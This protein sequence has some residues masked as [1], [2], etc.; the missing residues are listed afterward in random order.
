[1]SPG[2]RSL[3]LP[4]AGRQPAG[5]SPATPGPFAWLVEDLL[6]E[7]RDL[8]AVE[9]F[10]S[11]HDQGKVPSQSRYYQDLIPLSKP[12]AGQQY[13]FEVDLDSCTG[14]K[15]CVTACHSLNGLDDRETWRDVGLLVGGTMEQPVVQHV[16]TACHHCLEPECL[17]GCPVKAYEKDP[18][19]GIVKHLDDQCIGCQY[20]VFK[21]P[22]D[23]PK[24]NKRLGIVRK[25]DMCHGRLASGEAPACVQ[26]C[27]N[28]A[29]KIRV[30]DKR[31]VVEDC[32]SNRFVAGAPEPQF[33]LPSTNYVGK[34][35]LPRNLLPADFYQ[36]KPQPAHA[37]LAV[38][39][40]LTQLS[41]GALAT[42]EFLGSAVGLAPGGLAWLISHWLAFAAA[43]AGIATSV[44]HLGRPLYAFRA[45]LGLRKSW[46]SR[47]I[48]LFAGFLVSLAVLNGLLVRLPAAEANPFVHFL[49][50]ASIFLGAAGLICGIMIYHDTPRPFWAFPRSGFKFLLTT[51]ILGPAGLLLAQ[52][53]A[54]PL[55]S[56]ADFPTYLQADGRKL[57]WLILAFTSLKVVYEVSF[58]R[59]RWDRTH[60]PLRKSAQLM[61]GPLLKVFSARV[62]F[63]L[64]GGVALPLLLL[65]DGWNARSHGALQASS[66][67]FPF[68]FC[69]LLAG[70]LLERLLFFMAV[71]PPKM[72]GLGGEA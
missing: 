7:Q 49:I 9:R 22:Y 30:V 36:V 5:N 60:N 55:M 48:V 38:M 1:M 26:A 43:L 2:S 13:A 53:L 25:C 18:V 20:C 27:P 17:H 54:A 19:T 4:L 46:M 16:T 61:T 66:L 47:E 14:C 64:M 24:Y 23:V 62:V 71:T 29:I 59:H 69:L 58:L 40:V 65:I 51:A 63:G 45:F 52:V 3:E 37:P 39:L 10:A 8:T 70:E 57:L 67:L 56:G 34:K 28:R 21:C 42:G 68:S 6:W 50:M 35:A 72:P 12:Q 41:V 11:L 32:E 33:T 31:Q 44:L 15:A